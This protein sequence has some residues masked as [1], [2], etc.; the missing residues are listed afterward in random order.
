VS[1]DDRYFTVVYSGRVTDSL[2]AAGHRAKD[3]GRAHEVESAARLMDQWL[4]ADPETLG[5][6]YRVHRSRELTEYLGFVG[7][8]IVRYNIR[9]EAK[10]VFVV[11]PVRVARWAGF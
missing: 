4:R 6:P 5:E 2:V 9:H 8:L 11:Y 7:P 10:Q 1:A 3:V